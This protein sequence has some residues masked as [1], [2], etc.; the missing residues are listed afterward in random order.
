M[1][2]KAIATV[3]AL[4][5]KVSYYFLSVCQCNSCQ[6][7][8]TP[9][10]EFLCKPFFQ[11]TFPFKAS[12][13]KRLLFTTAWI[14][15]VSQQRKEIILQ[16]TGLVTFYFWSQ[17]YACFCFLQMFARLKIT[18]L[19]L[20]TTIMLSFARN[21][22]HLC[23]IFL[24]CW[25]LSNFKIFPLAAGGI[26]Y[27]GTKRSC[28]GKVLCILLP[29]TIRLVCPYNEQEEWYLIWNICSGLALKKLDKKL[30][31]TLLHSY[32]KVPISLTWCEPWVLMSFPTEY[33]CE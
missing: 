29:P 21:T 25:V 6:L 12:M 11:T 27:V 14:F 23:C 3:E 31:R 28:R 26:I 15:Q 13:P 9:Q 19:L 30:E 18:L 5:G 24:H 32:R 2:A 7:C 1:S 33:G 8:E 20:Y 17:C 22:H 4:E 10:P 16:F